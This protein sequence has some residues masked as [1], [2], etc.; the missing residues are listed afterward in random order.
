[1]FRFEKCESS[2]FFTSLGGGTAPLYTPLP[3]R[4]S[5]GKFTCLKLMKTIFYMGRGGGV[6]IRHCIP[7]S[8]EK[9]AHLHPCTPPGYGPDLHVLLIQWNPL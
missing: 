8:E 3:T 5:S 6:Q 9:G 2:E 4:I 1:M 7:L